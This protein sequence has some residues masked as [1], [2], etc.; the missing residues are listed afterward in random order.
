MCELSNSSRDN[1]RTASALLRCRVFDSKSLTIG[2]LREGIAR[3][4]TFDKARQTIVYPRENR[5][6]SSN[7]YD[8]KRS[9][10]YCPAAKR[11]ISIK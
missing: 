5:M 11:K 3:A 8:D 7:Y 4:A 10:Q 9:I 6:L 2:R 1:L